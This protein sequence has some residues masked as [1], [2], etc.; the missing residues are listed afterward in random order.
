MSENIQS[1]SMG[2]YTIGSTNELTFSAGPGIKVDQPSEGVVRIGN[3]E[4]VLWEN[5]AG[6]SESN[7]F[8]LS[9][10]MTNF[11]TIKYFGSTNTCRYCVEV[12]TYGAI[13]AVFRFGV[14]CMCPDSD[15]APLQLYG[16]TFNSTNG[17]TYTLS[18]SMGRW[19]DY[20]T[21]TSVNG[22]QPFPGTIYKIV[23]INRI[24]GSNA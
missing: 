6:A 22:T 13:T 15:G 18:R 17:L 23:G 19:F 21:Q 10:Q 4:T 1:I 20:N 12:P 11:N 14:A 8:T 9:E 16:K 7:G 3:D 2:T 24:S 5:S